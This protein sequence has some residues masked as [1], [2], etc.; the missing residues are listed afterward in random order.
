MSKV[1]FEAT[2]RHLDCIYLSL[3]SLDREQNRKRMANTAIA[4]HNLSEEKKG[5]TEDYIQ[6]SIRGENMI[7]IDT[8]TEFY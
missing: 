4:I 5:S 1:I 2:Y 3:Y 7:L 8:K 6:S